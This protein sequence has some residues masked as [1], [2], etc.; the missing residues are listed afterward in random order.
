MS[1][2]PSHARTRCGKTR[3]LPGS[4]WT[5]PMQV[6]HNQSGFP[7]FTAVRPRR[8]PLTR[9]LRKCF[10]VNATFLKYANR[11]C[12]QS[13]DFSFFQ[14]WTALV[15]PP[16][17]IYGHAQ[18]LPSHPA[19]PCGPVPTALSLCH[20]SFRIIRQRS[21]PA[22]PV[23]VPGTPAVSRGNFQTPRRFTPLHTSGSWTSSARCLRLAGRLFFW[24]A[25]GDEKQSIRNQYTPAFQRHF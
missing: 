13:A 15:P 19:A 9:H 4:H 1:Q 5:N 6:V 22:R 16:L 24:Q 23:L 20:V 21:G 8:Q 10:M 18:F 14:P 17:S 2:E 3:G 12:A 7:D 11:W 25:V